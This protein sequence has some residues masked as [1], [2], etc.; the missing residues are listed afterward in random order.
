MDKIYIYNVAN[1]NING[2]NQTDDEL[3]RK[4]PIEGSDEDYEACFVTHEIE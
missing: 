1:A 4:N 3:S 2:M